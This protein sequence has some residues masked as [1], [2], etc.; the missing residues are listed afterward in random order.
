MTFTSLQF[1]DAL[2]HFAT[3]IAI[4]TAADDDGAVAGLTVNS[5][6]SISLDPPL[7]LVSLARSIA[8]FVVFERAKHFAVSLLRED[9]RHV[10]AA[11]ATS[12]QAKWQGAPHRIG[13]IA[14]PIIHPNLAA[15]ECEVHARY[16]GG[17]HVL[18]LG[19]VLAVEASSD[20]GVRPLLYFRGRYR[21]LSDEH[22]ELAP[23][24]LEGW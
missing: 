14:C 23:F 24:R 12:G 2:S 21:E 5:F 17:D 10:S 7:V 19:R 4:V 20:P 3:G 8:S 15:F 18:L 1:R 22:S 6:T 13:T 16:D 9:Q 11:F